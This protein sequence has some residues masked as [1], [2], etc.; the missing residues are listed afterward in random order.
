VEL[1]RYDPAKKSVT[2]VVKNDGADIRSASTGPGGIVYDRFG[3]LFFYDAAS[4]Q[5]RRVNVD[6]SADLP[7]V[8]PRIS[9]VDRD[10]QN[11]GISPTGV[12]AVFEAHGDIFTV[13]AKESS[14]RDITNTPGVM[15]REPAWS[16]DGQSIAYFSDESGQYALHVRSFR[17]QPMQRFISTRCGHRTPNGSL[18]TITSWTS[19]C[20]IRR[21]EKPL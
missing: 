20:W 1:F 5:A 14:T 18:S 11:F 8:R 7:E 10:I 19:G 16:P 6:V 3:E 2:E 17:W 12:R 13:P 21:Q 9:P 4:G 15:E